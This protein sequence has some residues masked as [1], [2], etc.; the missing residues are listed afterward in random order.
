LSPPLASRSL[1]E[2]LADL[3]RGLGRDLGPV[4]SPA[5]WDAIGA[6]PGPFHGID[7]KA[8]EAIG[9]LGFVPGGQVPGNEE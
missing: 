3:A 8:W 5:L 1:V 9:P 2:F 4:D 6:M 7:G